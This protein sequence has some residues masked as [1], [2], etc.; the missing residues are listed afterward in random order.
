MKSS[1]ESYQSFVEL[2]NDLPKY[3]LTIQT[4]ADT[5]ARLIDRLLGEVLGW[6]T[7]TILREEHAHPGFMDYVLV[8]NRRV[9]VL[10]A[11]KSGDTF[12]LPHD[13]T[14]GKPFTLNGIIRKV[15]NLQAHINQV[16]NYCFNNGIEYAIVSNG[17]QYV[18]FRAVR[19]D[20]IHVGQGK[21]IVFNG[22]DDIDNRFVEFWELLAR[23]S[24]E[25]NSL[26]R[27]FSGPGHALSQYRRVADQ[28]HTFK[29]KVTRNYLSIELEPLI[30]EYMGE[31]TDEGSKEKLK[32]LFVRSKE[33]AV[34]LEA[35][36]CRMALGLSETVKHSGRVVETDTLLTLE[37]SIETKIKSHVAIPKR[38]EVALLLG[39]VGSG[40]STFVNHF[41]RFELGSIF[42]RPS[43]C[44]TRFQAVGE[45]WQYT[46]LF[47]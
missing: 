28:L 47:L 15:A 5:R 29:D 8:V 21:V 34:V 46:E 42:E 6:P 24:V 10:E 35:V 4:E 23:C 39:R 31:I 45:R 2:K 36:G 18:I 27:T 40:K 26:Q 14:S 9:A 20:G 17:L 37:A 19:I 43:S 32:H 33:L 41:L 38:G 22:F 13:I 1:E 44:P 11:K 25:D 7:E 16:T 12:Q 3:P 30:A